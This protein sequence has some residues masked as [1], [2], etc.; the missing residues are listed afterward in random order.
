MRSKAAAINLVILYLNFQSALADVYLHN[1]RGSN[2]R[3]NEKSATRNNNNRLFDSQNN[4]RGGYNVGDI[5]TAQLA[6]NGDESQIGRL[7][8]YEGTTLRT[9]W[10][11]QHGC[12]DPET[13]EKTHCNM[14]L[15][16]TC[17]S[18]LRDGTN[19]NTPN[20]NNDNGNTGRHESRTYYT[21][22]TSMTR[23]K[24]LFTADQ[25][26]NGN[27]AKYTRQ[28]PNGARSGLECPEERDY[29]PWWH[30][31]PWK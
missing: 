12:G 3:L 16:Y 13:S 24:G 5:G 19:T 10:T 17:S 9:E 25:K 28:N 15:Q 18:V 27:S 8:Y 20:T 29:Y 7:A 30:A 21:A 26:L 31:S 4:N 23:N 2:N 22:C 1:P 14:I 6:D 11:A